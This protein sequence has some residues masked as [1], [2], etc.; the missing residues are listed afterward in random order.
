MPNKKALSSKRRLLQILGILKHHQLTKG[1]D[2]VKVRE[3]IEEL[4]P[5]F[6]KIGQIMSTRQDMFSQRYCKELE[7]LRDDVAPLAYEDIKAVIEDEFGCA[8]EEV[9]PHFHKEPL[10]SASIAQVHQSQLVD[11]RQIVVK[12][13]RPH[14]YEMMERDIALVRRASSILKLSEI[15]GS[16]VDI[17][18]VLD[19][20]WTAAK[21]E[22]DFLIEAS[23]AIEFQHNNESLLYIATPQIY[24]EVSTPKVLVMEYIEGYTTNQLEVL[25]NEGYDKGEIAA[26]LADNYIKQIVDDGFFHADPHQGN[27]RIRD[28]KIVWIDFGMMGLLTPQDQDLMR[29]GIMAIVENDTG[30][31]VDVVLTLGVH[32]G[33]VDYP[34]LYTDMESLMN[35]Y[36]T[37][38]LADINL[39]LAVQEIFTVAHRHRISMP[40]GISML[41]RGLVTMESTLM[42]LDPKTNIINI[43]AGHMSG[44]VFRDLDVKKEARHL[45][46]KVYEAS[47]KTLDIPVQLSDV[48]RMAM[49]G[50]LKVNLE[51]MDS[52]QPL[53]LVDQM[54]NKL[55]VCI[56]AA[57]LLI[58]S[59][60]ICTTQMTPTLFGIP[61]LGFIGYVGAIILGIWM[62]FHTHIDK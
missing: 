6:V 51:I 52:L 42:E 15:L 2:P 14:I 11:G 43:A 34:L 32:N 37:M 46:R 24:R 9:F 36:L 8:I 30:K 13:Q 10:G 5:T 45:G 22:M 18:I 50:Q 38:E 20:F 61:L 49:K 33:K 26:K 40:K 41:A 47:N 53:S 54:V 59:S 4:G 56:G 23:N 31:L 62:L 57:A 3:I 35:R 17:N 19:E 28:G 7:K 55:V 25:Q 58:G 60:L 12:V 44:N 48:L 16:V 1:I 29:K 39:G 21:Q 27:I